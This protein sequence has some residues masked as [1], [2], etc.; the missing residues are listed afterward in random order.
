MRNE[1]LVLAS[2]K[3][4]QSAPKVGTSVNVKIVKT[5]SNTKNHIYAI[6]FD[7]YCQL[8]IIVNGSLHILQLSVLYHNVLHFSILHYTI[9]QFS[10]LLL[11]FGDTLYFKLQM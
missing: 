6:C 5:Q 10:T 3:C 9:S 2:N 11:H 1:V 7:N 4:K 8:A